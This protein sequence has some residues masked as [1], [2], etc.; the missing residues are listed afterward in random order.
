MGALIYGGVWAS[1]AVLVA[2]FG[3]GAGMGD[4]QYAGQYGI[5]SYDELRESL[6]GTGLYAHH[7]IPQRFAELL[8]IGRG[9]MPSVAV[10][11]AEHLRFTNEWRNHIPYGTGTENANIDIILDAAQKIYADCPALLESAKAFLKK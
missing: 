6:S 7:I 9:A 4:L 11:H 10:D 8:R 1:H 2:I 3:A 5:K